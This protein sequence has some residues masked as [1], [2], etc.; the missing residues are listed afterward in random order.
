L[1]INLISYA[2]ELLKMIVSVISDGYTKTVRNSKGTSIDINFCPWVWLSI[3]ISCKRRYNCGR[4]FTILV[5]NSI[6]RYPYVKLV[7][8]EE[9]INVSLDGSLRR[10]TAPNVRL[11][12]RA[13]HLRRP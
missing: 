4:I 2:I 5:P 9:K 7:V 12:N 13:P 8:V 3:D 11:P 10:H 6:N 1:R